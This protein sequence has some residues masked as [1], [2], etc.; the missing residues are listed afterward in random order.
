MKTK[1]SQDQRI[2]EYTA[3]TIAA[4]TNKWALNDGDASIMAAGMRLI[5]NSPLMEV[6]KLQAMISDRALIIYLIETGL[7]DEP[8]VSKAYK[9]AMALEIE[10][11][12][13]SLEEYQERL[14]K[15]LNHKGKKDK[16]SVATTDPQRTKP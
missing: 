6:I 11:H 10:Q 14:D 13:C 16:R 15:I 4:L 12:T 7:L 5:T 2:E 9:A 1:K 8:K 3:K